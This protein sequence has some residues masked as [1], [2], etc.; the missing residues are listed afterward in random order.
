MFMPARAKLN[1][2]ESKLSEA[3]INKEISLKTLW[4]F[5]MKKRNIENWK[6]TL[7]WMNSQRSDVEKISLIKE[8]KKIGVN[9]VIKPNEIINNTLK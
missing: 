4:L 7:E 2:I 6:K 3:F 9:E 8:G 5:L 1:S